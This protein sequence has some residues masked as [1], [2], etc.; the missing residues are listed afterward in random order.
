[1]SAVKIISSATEHE[2]NILSPPLP[3]LNVYSLICLF[4]N[5]GRK[6]S[7]PFVLPHFPKVAVLSLTFSL[8][9]RFSFSFRLPLLLRRQE[10]VPS[11]ARPA[12][13][14]QI[15]RKLRRLHE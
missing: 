1:M 11:L 13:Q 10:F 14:K 6:H 7:I 4:F 9:L 15:I 2:V 5:A 8:P 12:P 3:Q